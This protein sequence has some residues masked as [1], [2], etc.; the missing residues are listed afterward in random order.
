MKVLRISA[1][2]TLLLV[3]FPVTVKNVVPTP[4]TS[5][6]LVNLRDSIVK[7]ARKQLGRKYVFG[8]E[9]PRLGF[10][11][12]GLVQYV[13][14]AFHKGIPRTAR[15]QARLGKA[16]QDTLVPGDLLLFGKSVVRHIGIYTGAG[17]YIN[18]SSVAGEVIERPLDRTH[19]LG[20]RHLLLDTN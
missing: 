20:A 1:L 13:L 19:L 5:E 11:C 2:C 12:S 4:T 10:D 16:V 18:A 14:G 17:M 8:A 15:E 3:G 6:P 7:L 9:S